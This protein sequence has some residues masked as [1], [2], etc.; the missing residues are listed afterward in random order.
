MDIKR[1]GYGIEHEGFAAKDCHP[2]KGDQTKAAIT[3][4]TKANLD[5]L[6]GKY[7]RLRL[8]GRNLVA[9]SAAFEA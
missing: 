9:F 2:V 3:W 5:E 7:I 8:H 4:A 6:K 1:P